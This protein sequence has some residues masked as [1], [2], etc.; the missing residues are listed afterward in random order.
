MFVHKYLLLPIYRRTK[1]I[2]FHFKIGCRVFKV[3]RMRRTLISKHLD[4][5]HTVILQHQWQIQD[6]IANY[7]VAHAAVAI[8]LVLP[9]SLLPGQGL[10]LCNNLKSAKNISI[11]KF[12]QFYMTLLHSYHCY[13]PSKFI[14]S[15]NTML[16][17][18][19]LCI[20]RQKG[21]LS[22]SLGLVKK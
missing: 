9:L 15:V 11:S 1:Q 21:N 14:S 7:N 2:S 16:I 19:S 3:I 6:N 8:V 5:Q 22:T 10:V 4:P 18:L 20:I 17:H 12:T 13:Y